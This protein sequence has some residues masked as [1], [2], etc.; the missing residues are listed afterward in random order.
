L[1]DV[2]GSSV[3]LCRRSE[4]C[5]SGTRLSRWLKIE[6]IY[7]WVPKKNFYLVGS[8]GTLLVRR[9][10]SCCSRLLNKRNKKNIFF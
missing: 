10:V 6:F 2:C 8:C 1:L 4:V 5:C 7:Q 9:L 3:V